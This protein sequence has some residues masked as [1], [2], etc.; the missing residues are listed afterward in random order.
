MTVTKLL[1]GVD[2]PLSNHEFA[3]WVKYLEYKAELTEK[4]NKPKKTQ[5]PADREFKRTM[6]PK[7]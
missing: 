4:A 1:T 7:D 6:G 3:Y 5:G 2:K